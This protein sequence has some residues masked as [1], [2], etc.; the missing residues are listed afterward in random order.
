MRVCIWLSQNNRFK[1]LI[2]SP[3]ILNLE[4]IMK[5]VPINKTNQKIGRVNKLKFLAKITRSVNLG[6]Q[7]ST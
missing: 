3:K 6:Y 2:F 7:L 1:S 5:V 4:A